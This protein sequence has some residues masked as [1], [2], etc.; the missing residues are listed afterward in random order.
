MPVFIEPTQN[1]LATG[2]GELDRVAQQIGHRLEQQGA[3]AIEWRQPLRQLQFK[4]QAVVFRQG[5]VELMQFLQQR[6]RVELYEPG[7]TLAIL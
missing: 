2:R 7:S 5:Q 6:H 1:H 3:V 4:C